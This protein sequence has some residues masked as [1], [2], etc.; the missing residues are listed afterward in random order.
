MNKTQEKLLEIAKKFVDICDKNKLSYF[1]LGGTCLGAM[2]H[3]G[4]IPWDDD[5]DFAMPRE[6]YEK[7]VN[8]YQKDFGDDYFIQTNKTDKNYYLTY[9]KV[10]DNRTTA[11]EKTVCN[12][13]MNHGLWIDIFPLD[14][15]SERKKVNNFYDFLDFKFLRRR[16]QK[17]KY[18]NS[19][20][21]IKLAN[22][23]IKFI[24]PS[25]KIA[26]NLCLKLSKHYK[27][28]NSNRIWWMFEKRTRLD[29]KREWFDDYK[30]VNFETI[31]IRVPKYVDEYLTAHY[32]DWRTLPPVNQRKSVHN[33]TILDLDKS[34]KE[35]IKE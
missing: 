11:I 27:F 14:G 30:M 24:L 22:V 29:I 34:F 28:R 21:H 2:R 13:K 16:F 1:A 15:I 3:N 10:R 12:I 20:F 19:K 17:Y 5:I 6:D 32:G 31:E 18:I 7:F 8:L 35:Y 9:A 23:L 4:F 25:K 26:Y 33:I